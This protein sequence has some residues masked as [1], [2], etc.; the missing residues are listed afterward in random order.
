MI[1]ILGEREREREREREKGYMI[2]YVFCK[3]PLWHATFQL[4][5]RSKHKR[6]G[7]IDLFRLS[8]WSFVTYL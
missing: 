2:L 3:L 6:C 5:K 1:M 8:I 7:T 4:H